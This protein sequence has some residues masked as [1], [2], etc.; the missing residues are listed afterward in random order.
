M[1]S[2]KTKK[3]KI[4]VLILTGLL[5]ASFFLLNYLAGESYV[6]IGYGL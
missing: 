2:K 6:I 1:K 5:V 4:S 3:I